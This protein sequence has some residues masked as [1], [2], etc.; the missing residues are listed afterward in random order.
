MIPSDT[1]W[2]MNSDTWLPTA[3]ARVTLTKPPVNTGS[4]LRMHANHIESAQTEHSGQT[5]IVRPH[6]RNNDLT[7]PPATVCREYSESLL[8]SCVVFTGDQAVS[9]PRLRSDDAVSGKQSADLIMSD[10]F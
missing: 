10:P 1:G 4:A 7:R 8:V 2:R 3:S 5:G 6:H 9:H